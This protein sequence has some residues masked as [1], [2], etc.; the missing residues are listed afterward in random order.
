MC[1]DQELIQI[2]RLCVER[3]LWA[4][5]SLVHVQ[6]PVKVFGDVHGQFADLQRFFAAYVDCMLMNAHE[7]S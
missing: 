5:S 7:C 6:T 3:K 1:T 2:C 4:S